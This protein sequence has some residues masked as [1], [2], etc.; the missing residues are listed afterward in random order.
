MASSL[1]LDLENMVTKHQPPKKQVDENAA[2]AFIASV[3]RSRRARLNKP[4]LSFQ[5]GLVAFH[6]N[7]CSVTVERWALDYWPVY[8]TCVLTPELKDGRLTATVEAGYIGRLPIHPKV[9]RYMEVLFI[10]M[11]AAFNSDLKSVS[12]LNAI[13]LQDK[14]LTLTATAP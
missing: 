14:T 12:K 1:R 9:A 2:N 5:R 13:E 8:T 7:R 6:P 11:L 10:D 4:L 3:V